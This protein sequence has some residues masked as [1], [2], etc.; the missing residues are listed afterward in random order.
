MDNKERSNGSGPTI[1]V[2][3]DVNL[4]IRATALGLEAEDY[5]HDRMEIDELYT[6]TVELDCD[7]EDIDQFYSRGELT[8]PDPYHFPNEFI[9]L[10]R[11]AT[12]RAILRWARSIF[13]SSESFRST[14]TKT[15]FGVSGRATKSSRS[16]ST[17]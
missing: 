9:H 16:R 7:G 11:I 13:R 6:G 15:V 1:L 5:D 14:A 3:K 10:R 8:L 17:C 2:T 4:R 12:T